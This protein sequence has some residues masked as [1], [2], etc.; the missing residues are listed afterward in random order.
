MATFGSI[1][2]GP[3]MLQALSHR[4]YTNKISADRFIIAKLFG[5][6]E[7]L[8]GVNMDIWLGYTHQLTKGWGGATGID[9]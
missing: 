1:G 8:G 4:R 6:I 5:A 9:L 3:R 2:Q 7:V